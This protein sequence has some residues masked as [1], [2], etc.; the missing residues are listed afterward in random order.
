[1]PGT[2]AWYPLPIQFS[3]VVKDL[4]MSQVLRTTKEWVIR[5]ISSFFPSSDIV[6]NLQTLTHGGYYFAKAQL[7]VTVGKINKVSL[8][9]LY[10][11][12]LEGFSL[13]FPTQHTTL[14][15]RLL[16]VTVF[17]FQTGWEDPTCH[18][19]HGNPEKLFLPG[20]ISQQAE[21]DNEL[22]SLLF[23]KSPSKSH[24]CVPAIDSH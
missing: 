8:R 23:T 10:L 12:K 19:M 5:G 24:Q 21:A 7:C 20:K 14:E 6:K 17:P 22:L 16:L 11:S 4:F 13:L 9:T 1:M 18:H 15:G 3:Y 2:K